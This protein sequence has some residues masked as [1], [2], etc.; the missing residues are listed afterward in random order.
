M[1]CD[2]GWKKRS[3]G[4]DCSVK[5]CVAVTIDAFTKKLLYVG[6][7]NKYCYICFSSANAK[8]IRKDHFCFLNYNGNPKR[9]ETDILVQCFRSSEQMYG[10]QF[11]EFIGDGDSIFFFFFFFFF[12]FLS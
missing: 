2:G 3:K 10:L 4:H 12:F 11:L 6:I 7:R 8:V 9:M 5:G 1:I